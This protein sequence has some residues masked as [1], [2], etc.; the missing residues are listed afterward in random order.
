MLA[1]ESYTDLNFD[2]TTSIFHPAFPTARPAVMT[3]VLLPVLLITKKMM[4]LTMKNS[5]PARM[6]EAQ[7]QPVILFGHIRSQYF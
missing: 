4:S 7:L 1:V 6:N 2:D 3:P 5:R